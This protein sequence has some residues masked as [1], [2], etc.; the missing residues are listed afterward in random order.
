MK[1]IFLL[2][3]LI[4]CFSVEVTAQRINNTATYAA[5]YKQ[6][7]LEMLQR[8][9]A[10]TLT[11]VQKDSVAAVYYDVWQQLRAMKGKQPNTLKE[12]MQTL[13]N[14]RLQRLT[15]ALQDQALAQ[16]VV[17]Y[18]KSVR[19]NHLPNNRDSSSSL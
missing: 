13:E 5:R 9:G 11:S 15:S 1:N 3:I 7:V 6:S 8:P 4:S 16:Q 18:F 14:Y 2:F 10:V 17:N 12:S 19:L